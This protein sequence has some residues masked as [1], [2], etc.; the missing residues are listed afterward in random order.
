MLEEIS[1]IEEPTF[2]DFKNENGFVYWWAS[3]F[4]IMLGYSDM[5]SFQKAIDRATKAMISLNINHY[6]NII[7]TNKNDK[8]D[9]QLTRFAC[10]LIAMNGDTKKPE[11][12]TAQVYFINQARQF[13]LY[14][15]SQNEIER[16]VTREEFTDG[17]KLFS[18][19]AKQAGVTDYAKF[20]NAGYLGMYNMENW[21]LANKREVEPK[22]ILDTMGRLE[23]AANTFR[24]TLTE[25]RIKNQN[26]KGQANLEQAHYDVG[27]EVRAIV[28]KNSGQNPEDLK[29]E[30]GLPKVK[31]ELKKSYKKMEK[32]DKKEKTPKRLK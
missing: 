1:N 19:A 13:E 2:E 16:L 10:Y 32:I 18:S 28:I 29:Q 8:Q 30:V 4:M 3:D 11:V 24:V 12:A 15:E 27:C 22:N 6:E 21:K 23:L 7:A 20:V 31:K 5:K 17:Y 14:L 25:E 26:L 9:F